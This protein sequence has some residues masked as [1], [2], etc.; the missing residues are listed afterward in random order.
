MASTPAFPSAGRL[1]RAVLSAATTDKTGATTVNIADILTGVAAGTRI[2][3]VVIQAD[4][5]PADCT[6]ML[7]VYNGTDYRLFDDID[8]GDQAASSTTVVGYRTERVYED[9]ILPTA[10]FR[11]AAAITVVPTSGNVN[12]WAL[13]ADLT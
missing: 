6:L 7:F 13:G 12:V 2:R 4:G 10:S 8:L 9:L 1:G 11:I 5:N 3:R